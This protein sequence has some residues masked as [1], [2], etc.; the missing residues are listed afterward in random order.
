MGRSTGRKRGAAGTQERYE[1]RVTE[2]TDGVRA[3]V[4]E[5]VACWPDR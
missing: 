2:L 4:R 5:A 3:T 1:L